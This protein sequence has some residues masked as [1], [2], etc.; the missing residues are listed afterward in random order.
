MR[1]RLAVIGILVGGLTALPAISA[2][3]W[4]FF[5]AQQGC[6][7]EWEGPDGYRETAFSQGVA[8]FPVIRFSRADWG[9][10]VHPFTPF[11]AEMCGTA[12]GRASLRSLFPLEV[13]KRASHV[14]FGRT[15][16]LSVE[17][18]V[19][20][21]HLQNLPAFVV[22]GEISGQADSLSWW[23]PSVGWLVGFETGDFAKTVVSIDCP[24]GM[25]LPLF[26]S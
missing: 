15:V 6:K 10:S 8:S 5:V 14:A 25:R 16:R 9:P 13:G 17:E 4:P 22:R 12:A 7:F 2:E 1:A 19:E 18:A 3:D 24:D 21:A 23:A 11:C 26:L 20:V